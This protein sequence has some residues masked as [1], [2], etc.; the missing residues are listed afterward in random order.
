MTEEMQSGMPRALR[1]Y[2]VRGEGAAK[3]RWETRG[4][5]ERCVRAL[6]GIDGVRDPKGTCANLH[7]EATGKWPTEGKDLALEFAAQQHTG[8]MIAL[9]PTA[10]DAARFAMEDGEPEDE[11]HCTIAF[12]GKGDAWSYEQRLALAAEC[13]RAVADMG[14]VEAEAF[15]LSYF[16]PGDANDR[17]TALVYGIG[18]TAVDLAC[19]RLQAA[20]EKQGDPAPEQ[21][22]PWV[23]H[24]TAKY[25]TDLSEHQ[26][27]VDRMGPVTFD[28]VRLAFGGERYDI[29]LAMP[30]V[31]ELLELTASMGVYSPVIW[32]G[33]LAPIGKP[34][35]DR[36]IFPPGKLAFQTFPAPLRFQRE[37]REGHQGAVTVGRILHA[38]E[39]TWR[40]EPYIIGR[41]DFFNPQIIPEVTEAMALIEGGVAGPSVD[42]DSFTGVA[43]EVDGRTM[44]SVTEGRIRA[45]TLV[46]IPAFADLRLELSYPQDVDES[47]EDTIAAQAET[48]GEEFT[49]SLDAWEASLE[50][51]AASVNATGWRGAPVAPRDAEFDADDAVS[52]I[53]QY[54][55]VGTES[56]DEAKM[57]KM[58]LW[59]DPEGH[60]LD[61]KGYRLP[62]GD[63][64]DG[65]P[66]L[67]YHAIYAAA[68]LLEGGHGGLPNIP[69][70]DKA[71]L[72]GVISTIY[73]KLATEFG[74]PS[75]QAP[76]DRAAEK[77]RNARKASGMNTETFAIQGGFG[78]MPIAKGDPTWDK[79][80]A[81]RELDAWAGDDMSKYRRAFLY[82]EDGADPK[83]KG[84]YKFPVARPINGT[85]AIIPA[86]VR[87]AAAR[88]SGADV[89]DKEGLR[90]AIE[91]L[92]NRI[93]KMEA[94]FIDD[95][96][97][98]LV[99][100]QDFAALTDVRPAARM[101][102]D[103][104]LT[105]PTKPRIVDGRYFGHLALWDTCHL[106]FD[107]V[108][109]TPVPSKQGYRF[110]KAGTF[111]TAE[112]ET[113]EISKIM[114][115]GQHAATRRGLTAAA[116][117]RFY[118]DTTKVGGLVKIY[119]DRFGIAFSG[120]PAPWLS[121]TDRMRL[122]A[123]EISGHWHPIDGH[124]EL[125]AAIAVNRSGFPIAASGAPQLGGDV[126][127]LM[128]DGVQTGLI[129]SATFE[130]EE[131]DCGCEG[132]DS[133]RER[134]IARLAGHRPLPT[135]EEIRAR[136]ARL[137]AHLG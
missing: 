83:L 34:T 54:A 52:R 109:V 3:I 105:R 6:R 42:L 48:L 5:F 28:R 49:A 18:G 123:S 66:Y 1:D 24:M 119:P 118:E 108:C 124:L 58:F 55:G 68:A 92:M 7:H 36:R 4:A 10:E 57:R 77:A 72:R 94:A 63:I 30:A 67:I 106:G 97:A 60:P 46:A 91:S 59:V 127:V 88:V 64:I 74:D 125:L 38:E 53:E 27:L 56:P 9:I 120:I 14:P 61:R 79:G 133:E 76:W 47:V 51:F 62:W 107:G 135:Q 21:H 117:K 87:N 50:E 33:P 44:R 45:A 80:A 41:G 101:F 32:S 89:S 99:G 82:R 116:V 26:G 39:G 69:D 12:L 75:V 17:E 37:G 23:A 131:A 86:A 84:S 102:A 29:P 19:K 85:L 112:G 121:E 40:G 128:E 115:D 20:L 103:P 126:I 16:N 70:A 35:G 73:E 100:T 11:L 90:A 71:R 136:T 110:M 81:L 95:W 15:A 8:A 25:T 113:V 130:A 137:A 78:D 114:F 2:W 122:Q 43:T 132:E 98:D 31:P 96:S 93:H 65:K 111:T 134:R 104:Q 129:A 13:A 22:R